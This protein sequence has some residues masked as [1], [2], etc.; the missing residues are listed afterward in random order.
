[1]LH[2]LN[3]LLNTYTDMRKTE[4]LSNTMFH[5]KIVDYET[6][7]RSSILWKFNETLWPRQLTV[8]L[9]YLFY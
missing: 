1:M 6:V 7:D 3:I 5:K 9:Q 2:I 8:H 4:T